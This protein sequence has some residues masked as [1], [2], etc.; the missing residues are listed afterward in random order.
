TTDF[1]FVTQVG[2]TLTGT[3]EDD[4]LNGTDGND[5][6]NGGAG[7]DILSGGLGYD[8]LSGGTGADTFIWNKADV[9]TLVT[10]AEDEV[11][12]FN[13]TEN[14]VLNLA[15]LLSDGS[16]SIIGVESGGHLQIQVKDLGGDIVQT[17]DLNNVAAE[18][19]T[20]A[21][22]VID[23]WISIGVIDDGIM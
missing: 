23:N 9:G 22:G 11:L 5:I 19:S 16:H 14:D 21:Q 15:D 6:L 1:D 20:Y 4:Y 17:I 7:N 12:D 8:S 2:Q 13:E 3:A 10:P 18:N